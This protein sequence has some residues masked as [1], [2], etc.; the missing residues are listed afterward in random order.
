MNAKTHAFLI[1]ALANAGSNQGINSLGV[2]QSF[3]GITYFGFPIYVCP[4]CLMT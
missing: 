2:A 3:E 1:Q 4:E